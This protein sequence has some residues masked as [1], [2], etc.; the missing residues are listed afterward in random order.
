MEPVQL[1]DE[2][3]KAF[4]GKKICCVEKSLSYFDELCSKYD[5]W[6]Q[7]TFLVDE[8]P[9]SHGRFDYQGRSLEVYPLEQ[10]VKFDLSDTMLLITSD[11][12]REYYDKIKKLFAARSKMPDIYFWANLETSY[13]LFYRKQYANQCLEK[14]IVF[15]SGPHADHYVEGMDFS[16]NA[17][18]LFEYMLQINLNETYEL[19]WIVKSPEAFE[20]YKKYQN[21]SFLPFYAAASADK[22]LRDCYYRVLCLAK[23]FFFTDAY[24]FVRNCRP[25]QI[26]VQ[27]WHGCGYKRRLNHVP[28]ENRYDFMT[29]TSQLYA[30]L[31]AKEFGL[32]MDQM[33]VTGNAKADWLFHV[34]P[35]ILQKLCIPL[36]EHYVFWMPTYRFSKKEMRKPIDGWVKEET[37]LPLISSRQELVLINDQLVKNNVVMVIKLHPFQ[38]R[39]AVHVEEFSNIVILE[40]SLLTAHDI[41]I[42]QVLGAADALISDYSSTA[43]DYLVRKIGRAHV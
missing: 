7:V 19:V 24:G 13:E 3:I 8:N 20:S 9:G 26:R 35:E 12:Y 5:I 11:Y 36:A 25:D 14:I 23:Y 15:R 42:N 6:Q 16:D 29:V 33:L 10:L 39:N 30:Q 40:N 21:V 34:S 22:K 41:Q 32:R 2:N 18:A 31:H 4:Q 38:D 27:L 1:S 28:C 17:R 37:G 43:V